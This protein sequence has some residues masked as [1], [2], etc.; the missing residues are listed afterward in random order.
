MD[1]NFLHHRATVSGAAEA[2]PGAARAGPTRSGKGHIDWNAAQR[3]GRAC[4]CSAKPAVIAV[5][6]PVKGRRHSTELLLCGHHYRASKRALAAAGATVWD[7]NSASV[8]DDGW[9]LPEGA[10]VAGGAVSP[11]G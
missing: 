11:P 8:T 2:P 9:A 3:A 4:C 7:M 10:R 5:M 6:P 1:V